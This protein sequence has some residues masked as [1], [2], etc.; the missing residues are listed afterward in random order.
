MGPGDVGFIGP[1]SALADFQGQAEPHETRLTG[2]Y[3]SP[4]AVVQ[5]SVLSFLLPLWLRLLWLVQL[6]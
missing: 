6:Y 4:C 2:Y 3:C 1:C 5:T